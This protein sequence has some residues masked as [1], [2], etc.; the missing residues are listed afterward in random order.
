M[1]EA[2]DAR[3]EGPG[4]VYVL[5]TGRSGSTLLEML[6]A[7]YIDLVTVGEV[8]LLGYEMADRRHL[9]SCGR[10]TADCDFWAAATAGLPRDLNGAGLNRFRVAHNRGRTLRPGPLLRMLL[11]TG[12]DAGDR[13]YARLNAALLAGAART[14]ETRDG[15]PVA[16]V[17]DASKDPYR[18][19]ALAL[20]GQ[21]PMRVIHLLRGPM[22]FVHSQTK[23]ESR[24]RRGLARRLAVLRCALRWRVANMVYA[25][26]ARRCRPRSQVVRLWYEDLAADPQGV[27]T[28][29]AADL[30]LPLRAGP[31]LDVV[32]AISGSRL[33]GGSHAVRVDDSWKTAL[34]PVDR[35]IVGLV[36]GGLELRIRREMSA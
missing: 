33:R 36:C 26:A 32:H 5:S 8:Q 3:V 1:S 15:R 23:G 29:L 17:A 22:G 30:G 16:W 24:P 18:C 27:I 21:A 11:G 34:H 9:C 4:I 6:L 10:P 13:D 12:P 20:A 7:R 35:R 14:A 25:L 2:G 31:A 28:R 19:H